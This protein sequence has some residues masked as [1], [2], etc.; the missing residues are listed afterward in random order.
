MSIS[1]EQVR[2]LDQ[3]R[4]R[5]S[6]LSTSIQALQADLQRSEPLPTPASLQQSA[7]MLAYNQAQV[8][9]LLSQHQQF[10][11]SA[12]SYP[13]PNFPGHTQE[14]LLIELMRKK[15]EPRAESWID[16][17]TESEAGQKKGPL[18][19]QDVRELWNW[20]GPTSNSVVRQLIEDGAFDDDYTLA[21]RE[22]GVENVVTG[23]KRNLDADEEDEGE[24]KDEHENDKM[25]DVRPNGPRLDMDP[26]LPPL[27]LESWLRFISTAGG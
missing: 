13:L 3:L 4:Q 26:T 16:R 15:L 7:Q 20:A 12:H 23:L 8:Q 19:D 21:E 5:L 18:S 9:L 27:P 2:T 24:D 22:D 14:G 17:Y 25:E 6:Q 10:F 11:A 1:A